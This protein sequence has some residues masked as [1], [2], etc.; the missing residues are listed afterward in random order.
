MS[1]T[2]D[3]RLIYLPSLEGAFWN[4]V[5]GEDGEIVTK[6]VTNSASHNTIIGLE[7]R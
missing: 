5:R 2:P 3:G 1:I 4:V 7:G 6:V